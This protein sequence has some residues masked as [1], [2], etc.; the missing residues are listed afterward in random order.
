ML[1][2]SSFILNTP[3]FIDATLLQLLHHLYSSFSY[4]SKH[5]IIIPLLFKHSFIFDHP[6]L[7]VRYLTRTF[8]S[9]HIFINSDIPSEVDPS[10]LLK[11]ICPK[12]LT[13]NCRT[14]IVRHLSQTFNSPSTLTIS[15][16]H[17]CQQ[18]NSP[19]LQHATRIRPLRRRW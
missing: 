14:F 4:L 1:P 16:H 7:N 19:Q 5:L 12:T 9:G 6:H 18:L 3:S 11:I 15:T 8:N 10:G 17:Y 2:S 13:L